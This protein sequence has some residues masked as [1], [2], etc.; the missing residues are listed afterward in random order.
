MKKLTEKQRREAR[1]ELAMLDGAPP[2]NTWSNICYGDAYFAASLT[3]KYEVGDLT[4]L[5]RA[6]NYVRK[7]GKMPDWD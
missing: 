4:E 3:R 5:R 2:H 6:V 1:D 7:P